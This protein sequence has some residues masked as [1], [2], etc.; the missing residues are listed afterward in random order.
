MRIE[1][2]DQKEYQEIPLYP[3]GD[4]Q[5]N[6]L[7]FFAGR[8]DRDGDLSPLHR[9]S[10]IQINYI[11]KGRLLHRINNSCYELV[12]GDIF[13]IP[14]YIPHQLIPCGKSDFEFVEIEFM[15]EFVFSQ[16]N[17][18]YDDIARD[19]ALFDF[20]YIEPFLVTECNVRPRLNLTGTSQVKVEALIEEIL[21]EFGTREDGYLMALKADLLKLLV[22][23]GRIFRESIKSSP[24]MQLFNHHRDAMAETLRFIDQNFDQPITIEEAARHALLSQSYFSYL[25]KMLTNR[26]FVEYLHERRIQ[27]AMTLLRESAD[28]VLDICYSCG[29]NNVNHFNRI[30]KS[31][32][33]I[34]P[35]QYRNSCR[36]ESSSEKERS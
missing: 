7:P 2:L 35:T 5:D 10:V 26:T 28:R 20:S 17:T 11:S 25:F 1:E 3:L 21:Q 13:V 22:I 8:Y 30:F 34:S 33:G 19:S 29:F 4:G 24:E 18:Q 16:G 23:T 14:P 32:V 6:R 9:H 15:P 31:I 12:R 36:K 27:K